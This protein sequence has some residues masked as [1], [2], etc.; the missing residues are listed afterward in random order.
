MEEPGVSVSALVQSISADVARV[1][2][3]VS[4]VHQRGH[5]KEKGSV[6]P[7]FVSI[8]PFSL[9]RI[10]FPPFCLLGLLSEA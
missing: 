5:E 8:S 6:L 4:P 10:F 7:A 1:L 9:D 2:T 3:S